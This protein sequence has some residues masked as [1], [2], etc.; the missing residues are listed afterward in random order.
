MTNRSIRPDG[1]CAN[2]LRPVNLI[3]D[4]IAAGPEPISCWAANTDG[5]GGLTPA[6]AYRLLNYLA[7]GPD[8]D[9]RPCE[10]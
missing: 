6:D 2:E 9:C 10:F 3:L 8:L 7:S 4:Y 5:Q 1:R